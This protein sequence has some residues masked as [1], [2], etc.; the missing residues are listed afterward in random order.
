L[1]S[2][3][4]FEENN[5]EIN[6]ADQFTGSVTAIGQDKTYN[7]SVTS[8]PTSAGRKRFQIV[9]PT[10]TV[11]DPVIS[12]DGNTLTSNVA[13]GNQWLYNGE[14]IEGATGQTY[15]AE[16]TGEYHLLITKEGCSKVSQPVAITVTVT[17]VF[18]Q[19]NKGISFYPNPASEFIQVQS[20]SLPTSTVMYSIVDGTGKTVSAGEIDAVSMLKGTTLDVSHLPAGIYFLMLRAT[21]WQHQAKVFVK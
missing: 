18:E 10:G 5:S 14:E 2:G 21:S 20:L 11:E 12:V 17:D 8:D 9:M 1:F 13:T 15:V 16:A 19:H 3:P 4:W 7:F 6:L